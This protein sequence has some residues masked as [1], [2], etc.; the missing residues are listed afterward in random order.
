[1][2]SMT[3]IRTLQQAFEQFER[4][5]VRVP[6]HEIDAAKK[7]HKELRAAVEEALGESCIRTFLAGS[8]RRRTQAVHLKDLDIIV[9]LD[10]LTGELRRSPNAALAM[11]KTVGQTCDLVSSATTKCRAVECELTGYSFWADLVPALDDGVGGLLLAYVDRKEEIE[12]WRL[13]DPEG[14]TAACQEKNSETDGAYVPVTRICKFWN[15]SFT[16]SP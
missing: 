16:S 4:D 12:E 5:S 6:V 8:Y 14:Q 15:G 3:G 10:D 11:M 1:M 9:V 2:T 7:A 13:A